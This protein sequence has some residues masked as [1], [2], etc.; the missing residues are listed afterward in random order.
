MRGDGWE[1]YLEGRERMDLIKTA[2]PQWM[3]VNVSGTE[4]LDEF[5]DHTGIITAISY[6]SITTLFISPRHDLV[7][8]KEPRP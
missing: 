6:F 3:N 1:D 8:F 7:I 2:R 5:F 4:R